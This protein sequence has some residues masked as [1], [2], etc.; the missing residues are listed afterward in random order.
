M[1]GREEPEIAG[2]HNGGMTHRATVPVIDF[3][4]VLHP[5]PNRQIIRAGTDLR[6]R[7][8]ESFVPLPHL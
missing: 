3:S 1:F 5:Q 7:L 8:P 6:I 2:P 4:G